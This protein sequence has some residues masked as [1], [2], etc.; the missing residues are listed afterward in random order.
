MSSLDEDAERTFNFELA[1]K[2]TDGVVVV[3]S[4][5]DGS[6]KSTMDGAVNTYGIVCRFARASGKPRAEVERKVDGDAVGR[7]AE[8]F[9]H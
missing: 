7:P 2:F 6:K 3:V 8:W 4:R 1:L 5:I 9:A